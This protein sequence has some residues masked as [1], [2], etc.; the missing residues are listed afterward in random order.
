MEQKRPVGRPRIHV[1]QAARQKAWRERH[2][3][4]VRERQRGYDLKRTPGHVNARVAKYRVGDAVVPATDLDV[5]RELHVQAARLCTRQREW[6]VDHV[7]PL[8]GR[9]V[10]G[11]H[12]SWNMQILPQQANQQ[13]HRKFDQEEESAIQHAFTLARL[14]A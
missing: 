4:E 9:L 11:L 1:D 2:P 8:R 5:I 3:E 10:S 14:K 12:V 6:H 13:K 7:I